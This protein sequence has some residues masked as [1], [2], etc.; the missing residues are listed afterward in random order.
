MSKKKRIWENLID[1][2]Y[3]DAIKSSTMVFIDLLIIPEL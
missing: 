1:N 2:F 3:I